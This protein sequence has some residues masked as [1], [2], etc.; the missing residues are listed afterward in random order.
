MAE[1]RAYRHAWRQAFQDLLTE[2]SI[3][4]PPDTI[5]EVVEQPADQALLEPL[6]STPFA[7][8]STPDQVSA[9]APPPTQAPL[10]AP[11]TEDNV[12]N[13]ITAFDGASDKKSLDRVV[14]DS[15]AFTF[16]QNQL[17]KLRVTYTIAEK[18][19]GLRK[20]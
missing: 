16:T 4:L 12:L 7:E 11:A 5:D 20:V 1:N 15:K 6:V 14:E 10:P 18:R 9:V 17:T 2:Y 8:T 13:L 19:L 3:E